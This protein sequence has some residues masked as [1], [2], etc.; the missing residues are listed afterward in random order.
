MNRLITL[1]L[2]MLFLIL[3]A[4]ATLALPADENVPF[5]RLHTDEGEILLALF[6]DLAPN[7]C[8][9]FQHLART[10]FYDDTYFHR[11]I[12]GFMIQGGSG[13][14][15]DFDPRNDG[16][17]GIV[18]ADVVS[19]EEKEQ[20]EQ[21][22]SSLAARGYTGSVSQAP[23]ALKTEF[24]RTA[25]H[26]RGTLSMARRGRPVDSATSQFFICHERGASTAA[27]D[28]K[29]TILGQAVTGLDA[30]DRI[31]NAE[32]DRRKGEGFPVTPVKIIRCDL[33]TGL[34]SLSAEEQ[35]AYRSMVQLLADNESTW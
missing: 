8:A 5:V 27:L 23:V 1:V 6:P 33:S 28:G 7:H 21:I 25:K 3:T 14:T 34:A 4:G 17:G 12:P 22:E 35:E 20:L 15:K 29:Y 11:V 2:A 13:A 26:F 9:N 19:A 24:S 16:A 10:G 30:V 32:T 31:V 18:L